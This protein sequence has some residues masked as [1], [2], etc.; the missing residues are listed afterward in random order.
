MA[1]FEDVLRLRDE[2]SGK[3]VKMAA[4]MD[5]FDKKTK[6][7]S[8][9]LEKFGKIDKN[10]ANGALRLAGKFFRAES[11][12]GRKFLCRLVD[13]LDDHLSGGQGEIDLPHQRRPPEIEGRSG[14]RALIW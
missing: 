14:N 5:N 11:H 1:T 3:L 10:L 12:N 9:S 7:T 2:V 8:F 13:L 6:K 4:G